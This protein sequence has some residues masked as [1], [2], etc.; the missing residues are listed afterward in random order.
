MFNDGEITLYITNIPYATDY[1]SLREIF[2]TFGKI[3]HLYMKKDPENQKFLGSAYITYLR[4]SDGLKAIQQMEGASFH[5]NI[6]HAREAKH[7][8][9]RMFHQK[10]GKKIGGQ[11]NR[12]GINN[13]SP[14]NNQNQNNTSQSVQQLNQMQ[15]QQENQ[16]AVEKDTQNSTEGETN[17]NNGN[18]KNNE[19][20]HSMNCD[21]ANNNN[22]NNSSINVD[23]NPKSNETNNINEEDQNNE[24]TNDSNVAENENE[25]NQLVNERNTE[26]IQQT[27]TQ[28]NEN[29]NKDKNKMNEKSVSQKPKLS[30]N[31][32]YAEYGITLAQSRHSPR[33]SRQRMRPYRQYHEPNNIADPPDTPVGYNRT[34]NNNHNYNRRN[35]NYHDSF[36]DDNYR[37]NNFPRYH[38]YPAN[39]PYDRMESSYPRHIADRIPDYIPDRFPDRIDRIDRIDRMPERIPERMPERIPE[40]MP[41]RIPERIHDRMGDRYDDRMIDR[42]HGYDARYDDRPPMGPPR[43][44]PRGPDPGYYEGH[45]PNEIDPYQQPQVPQFQPIFIPVDPSLLMNPQAMMAGGFP[46][47]MMPMGILPDISASVNGGSNMMN[48]TRNDINRQIPSPPP[49]TTHASNSNPDYNKHPDDGYIYDSP[50]HAY[51]SS[52]QEQELRS[53]KQR[54]FSRQHQLQQQEGSRPMQQMI[55]GKQLPN[56]KNSQD[57]S[58]FSNNNESD[59]DDEDENRYQIQSPGYVDSPVLEKQGGYQPPHS[60]MN[61]NSLPIVAPMEMEIEEIEYEYSDGDN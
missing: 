52:L 20:Q 53:I 7:S 23:Y 4:E 40:R 8:M 42:Y 35:S 13:L 41:E 57:S 58:H 43:G 25:N 61:A 38:H 27:N 6:L 30:P 48:P 55:N 51:A 36:D 39:P 19:N 10:F 54:Q 32:I 46:M 37:S 44:V 17:E 22:D 47:A 28:N 59:D 14:Q 45:Y 56:M 31:Q 60:S 12:H 26:N 18:I 1:H 24:I 9:A 2:A 34:I 50:S 5:G 21:D 15:N 33:N 16:S 29:E 49:Q 11:Q 3:A